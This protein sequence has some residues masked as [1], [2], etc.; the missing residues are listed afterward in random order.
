MTSIC[1]LDVGT[2][3]QNVNDVRKKMNPPA[4]GADPAGE[5]DSKWWQRIWKKGGVF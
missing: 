1:S 2:V 3:L 4:P 5:N